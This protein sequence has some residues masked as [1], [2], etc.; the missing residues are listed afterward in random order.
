VNIGNG[1]SGAS[2]IADGDQFVGVSIE[3]ALSR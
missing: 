1:L 3:F 2:L